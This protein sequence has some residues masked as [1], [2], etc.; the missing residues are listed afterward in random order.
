MRALLH[1]NP[2]ARV[3]LWIRNGAAPQAPQEL[4]QRYA[5]TTGFTRGRGMSRELTPKYGFW[6][7]PLFSVKSYKNGS[8]LKVK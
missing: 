4:G 2:D 1:V 3:D 5:L 8:L 6:R 7:C